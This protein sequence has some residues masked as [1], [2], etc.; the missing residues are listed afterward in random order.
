MV[1]DATASMKHLI[2]Q[3]KSNALRFYDDLKGVMEAK[4]KSID[5]LRVKVIA[6]RDFWADGKHALVISD[7]ESCS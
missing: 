6:Y 5:H 1:V 2:E 3:V 7:T 4:S